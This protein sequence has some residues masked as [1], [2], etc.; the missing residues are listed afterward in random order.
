MVRIGLFLSKL[1][2]LIIRGLSKIS[3]GKRI[4]LFILLLIISIVGISSYQVFTS[5]RDTII[6]SEQEEMQ[7]NLALIKSSLEV[8]QAEL[9][10]IAETLAKTPLVR[11][12]V[13]NKEYDIPLWSYIKRDFILDGFE[14][15]DYDFKTVVKD[16]FTGVDFDEDLTLK[17][18]IED[19][20]LL[21]MGSVTLTFFTQNK[22][23]IRIN[24]IS[25]I[26]DEFQIP[27]LGAILITKSIGPEFFQ[28]LPISNEYSKQLY[29][30]Q[31]IMVERT[32][33]ELVQGQ[34]VVDEAVINY[35]KQPEEDSYLTRTLELNNTPYLVGYLPIRDFN[36]ETLGYFTL[37]KSQIGSNN[38][39]NN[40]IIKTAINGLV[41]I[42]VS[43]VFVFLISRSITVPI[44]E[45][46]RVTKR[47]AQ[48]DLSNRVEYKTNDRLGILTDNFNMM[49]DSLTEIVNSI[50][51]S[52]KQVNEMSQM[53]SAHSE[54]ANAS[55]EEVAASSEEIA[56]GTQEQVRQTE[57]TRSLLTKIEEDARNVELGS[58]KVVEAVQEAYNN[59]NQ[60][61]T[62]INDA[63]ENMSNALKQVARTREEVSILEEKIRE[64]NKIIESINYINE[65]TTLLSLNAQIE[66][67]RAGEAGRGFAV[68]ADEVRKL[69]D[70][71]SN[72]VSE[73]NKIFVQ[74]SEA[75]ERVAELTEESSNSVDEGE[76]A[77]KGAQAVF[78]D[79]QLAID[80]AKA[81]SQRINQLVQEQ[82]KGAM[83][84]A[85]MIEEVNCIAQLN[86]EGAE[87]TSRVNEEQVYIIEEIANSASELT[88]MA[89]QLEK[90]ITHFK[91]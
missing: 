21:G 47:V 58:G 80:R 88:E 72:L 49:I 60:G 28:H 3:I 19:I 44:G 32:R 30:G 79:I 6:K 70:Q 67:A 48:G 83:E 54:E 9:A 41:F 31:K 26:I 86:A 71:S 27:G 75:M 89:S 68:V 82:K 15:R 20:M 17:S 63:T 34:N 35:F 90:L 66:A 46:L 7:Q 8:Q 65:E 73:I 59:A 69:A 61:I 45:L 2:K 77:V 16:G 12:T 74:I 64:I 24:S 4:M 76:G 85:D 37:L 62:I 78:N 10:G 81:V 91:T 11:E 23:Y 25:S 53:L 13:Y 38:I 42:L 33:D 50:S 18:K 14:I 56:S 39:I 84:M 5:Y 22:D 40:L 51:N 55:T 52:S 1:E 43:L 87:Q 29:Y 57:K 36:G